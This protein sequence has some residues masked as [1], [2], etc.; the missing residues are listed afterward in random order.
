M[1]KVI[2]TNI[3]LGY[4]S[5]I[6]D[7]QSRIIEVESWISFIDEVKNRQPV[8]R[9]SYMGSIHGLTIPT[10]CK[11]VNFVELDESHF[12]C[13]IIHFDGRETLKLAYLV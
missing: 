1:V 9:K 6:A 11:V 3:S 12:K 8:E 10:R 5:T 2:E 7:F 4:N 13:T